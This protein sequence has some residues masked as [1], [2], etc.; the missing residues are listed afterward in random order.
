MRVLATATLVIAATTVL[1]AQAVRNVPRI[2]IDERNGPDAP[3]ADASMRMSFDAPD[4]APDLE[5]NEIIWK[6]VHGR[7]A[8]MPPPVRA[9]WVRA[10]READD[11]ERKPR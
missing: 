7:D 4:R 3:G 5:L 11:R 2:S 1:A 10:V 8:V 9:A 6:S